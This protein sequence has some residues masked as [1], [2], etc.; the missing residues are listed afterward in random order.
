MPKWSHKGKLVERA[1]EILLLCNC[2]QYGSTGDTYVWVFYLEAEMIVEEN[3]ARHKVE[4]R[5]EVHV[6]H[7]VSI[8]I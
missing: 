5:E 3:N 8:S 4:G 6:C 1:M 7:R 2:C